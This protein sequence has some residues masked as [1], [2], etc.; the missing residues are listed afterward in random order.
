[1]NKKILVTGGN[2]FIGSHVVRKL[3]AQGD[4]P[5][6]LTRKSSNMWRLTDIINQIG[7]FNVNEKPLNELFRHENLSGVINLATYYKK[8]NSFEDMD[9][10]VDSNIKFPSQLLQLC[11]DYNVPIFITAG[12]YFQYGVNTILSTVDNNIPRN[13]Y[14]ATKSAF[15]KI[16]DYYS[17]STSLNI[18]ELILFT[19]Y[20]EMDHDEKLIPYLIRNAL[21]GKPVNL[22]GGFQKLN[23]VYVEDVASAFVSALNSHIEKNKNVHLNISN[24]RSYSIRDII[25]V[26]EEILHKR[27]NVNW[28]SFSLNEV[29]KDDMLVVDTK[30]AEMILRWKPQF[31][32]YEG[33]RRTIDYYRG[34]VDNN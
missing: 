29:D 14:A 24:S 22:T 27:I 21:L 33:L 15:S 34:V 11:K 4:L 31:D 32:L 13:F 20:G 9:K 2:G 6:L 12:S 17:S 3:L 5:V 7:T 16:M 18:M 28:N 26:M 23:L 25:T 19:P 10:M 1:M 30:N 8:Q